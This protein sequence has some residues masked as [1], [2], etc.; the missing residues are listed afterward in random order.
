[1]PL[2]LLLGV[3][4]IYLWAGW[5]KKKEWLALKSEMV[6]AGESFDA[7]D[8][9]PPEVPDEENVLKDEWFLGLLEKVG[10]DNNYH[11]VVFGELVAF[12]G[13]GE[14]YSQ[15]NFAGPNPTRGVEM[16]F[17]DLTA[18]AAVDEVSQKELAAR[19]LQRLRED[20]N[21][22][23]QLDRVMKLE[24]F[25]GEDQDYEAFFVEDRVAI[26]VRLCEI[27]TQIA[28]MHSMIGDT[29]QALRWLENS[30]NAIRWGRLH[31]QDI[32]QLVEQNCE[33]QVQ[34]G[35]W[36][37]Q[38]T[39]ADNSPVIDA[40][41]QMLVISE[42]DPD[43]LLKVI[44][45]DIAAQIWMIKTMSP[46]GWA[47]MLSM[48]SSSGAE[49]RML[50]AILS[51]D[52]VRYRMMANVVENTLPAIQKFEKTSPR[53]PLRELIRTIDSHRMT[54][55]SGNPIDEILVQ[56]LINLSL[57]Y[58]AIMKKALDTE[59][60]W[61]VLRVQLAIRKFVIDEGRMP[62]GFDE[63]VPNYLASIPVDPFNLEPLR[64]ATDDRGEPLI[65]SVGVNL[66]D[67]GGDI[68]DEEYSQPNDIGFLL[69][70]RE[71][72]NEE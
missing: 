62:K 41:D 12:P 55:A 48:S 11:G 51:T 70:S 67:D 65:Y 36:Q 19:L 9:Y 42:D 63:L 39:Y 4:V 37:L 69:S 34:N 44:R 68:G 6:V 15:E 64:W 10:E 1:M 45:A 25:R 71:R 30:A 14:M 27:S 31:N 56:C 24:G 53:P 16:K 52:P 26:K 47:G 40:L 7:R 8:F 54:G 61:R 46:E 59:V 5:K 28:L 72:D 33:R 2:I 38:A 58:R 57:P 3:A 23:S 66:T 22:A 50:G 60:G 32:A 29:D 17:V 18:S 43:E 20:E 21:M 13:T 49:H 35:I